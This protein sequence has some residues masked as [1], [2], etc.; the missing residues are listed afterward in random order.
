MLERRV[1][2]EVQELK[3]LRIETDV[4]TLQLEEDRVRMERKQAKAL[5][6]SVQKVAASTG[7]KT[8][9]VTELIEKALTEVSSH[10]T[11][12][13]HATLGRAREILERLKTGELPTSTD[14]SSVMEE[15]M[16]FVPNAKGNMSVLRS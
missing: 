11:P 16:I 3:R 15:V 12:E 1:Q 9:S 7:K 10:S 13:A 6:G 4:A 2:D 8:T 14:G 5:P